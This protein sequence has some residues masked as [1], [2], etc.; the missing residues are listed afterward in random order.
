MEKEVIETEKEGNLL[1]DISKIVESAQRYAY[2]SVDRILVIR[3]W[4]L[5]RRIVIENLQGTRERTV[6]IKNSR[7]VS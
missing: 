4:L 7:R 5:G 2:Q 1:E 6:W 3:N